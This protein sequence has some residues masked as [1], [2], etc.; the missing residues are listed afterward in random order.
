TGPSLSR[1]NGAENGATSRPILSPEWCRITRR[2]PRRPRSAKPS[3]SRG[4]LAPVYRR[5]VPTREGKPRRL[6]GRRENT[7]AENPKVVFH[8]ALR[9]G[10]RLAP[11]LGAPITGGLGRFRIA[12]G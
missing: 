6:R 4:P 1:P 3:C 7:S 11:S 2:S 12:A 8:A 10:T 9:G 5:S